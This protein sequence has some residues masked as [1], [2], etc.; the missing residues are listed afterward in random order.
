MSAPRKTIHFVSLG[1]PKNRVDTEVMLGVGAGEGFQLVSEP[2]DAEV[3]VVNTCGFIGPAKEESIDTI[4]E[5]GGF[6]EAGSC[7]KLVVTGCLSQR[8]PEELAKEMPEVDHFL[9]TSDMLKLGAVLRAS[10][11]HP[12]ARMLVGN[13]AEYSFRAT[14]PR[15]LSMAKHS[16]YVKIAEGCSRTCSFCIIPSMRGKQRSRPLEDIVAEVEQLVANGTN[17]INLVS[18]DTIS[19][20]RDLKEDGRNLAHLV[21]AIGDVKGLRW[22]RLFYLY[23]EKLTEELIELIAHHPRVLPYVDMPLQHASERMLKIMR[24]GHGPGIQRRVVERM[25]TQI[26]DLT[27]RTAFIVGHPGETDADFQELCEFVK[28]AEFERVG[29][30]KYSHEEGTRSEKLEQLVP[31]KTISARHRKLMQLQR[32]ISKRKLRG[33]IGKELEVLVEGVSDESEFLLEGRHAGQAPE[34]DGKVYL[35]NGE[36]EPGELRRAIVTD[37]A[38]YDLVADLLPRQGGTADRPPG[39]KKVRLKTLGTANP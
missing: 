3:I 29:V 9:G 17:E 1:C 22:L 34:I 24:R 2:S 25:R 23:P 14:D 10:E 33:L 35:A 21:K 8:Y 37:A 7:R 11:D 27:F 19:Y 32:P 16:A 31:E 6:K 28:W 26:P 18:Q 4:L 15:M 5:M 20:G 39:A 12:L 38:D 30:F 13:P 36:S